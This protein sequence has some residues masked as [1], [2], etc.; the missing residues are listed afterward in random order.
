MRYLFARA[1]RQY[2]QLKTQRSHPL[3]LIS[4]EKPKLNHPILNHLFWK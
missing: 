1:R 4:L 2:L 3:I